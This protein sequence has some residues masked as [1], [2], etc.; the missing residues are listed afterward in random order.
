MNTDKNCTCL[1]NVLHWKRIELKMILTKVV[2]MNRCSNTK[3][4]FR[5]SRYFFDYKNW[6]KN[7]KFTIFDL[8]HTSC[9]TKYQKILWEGLLG[10]DIYWISPET[11]WNSTT[12]GTLPI[13]LCMKQN[14]GS[15]KFWK[16]ILKYCQATINYWLKRAFQ[17]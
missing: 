17:K 10:I 1:L 5:T 6:F 9:L 11:L 14:R 2:H 7:W 12:V 4:I 3:I 16:M 13:A 8:P 15:L